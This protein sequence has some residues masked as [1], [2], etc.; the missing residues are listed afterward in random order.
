MSDTRADSH[1]LMFLRLAAE[2][3]EMA[4]RVPQR[5][6]KAHFVSVAGEWEDLAVDPQRA[7]FDT[8]SR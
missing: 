7:P 3:R 2:C 1:A 5:K 6:L 4:E 8:S